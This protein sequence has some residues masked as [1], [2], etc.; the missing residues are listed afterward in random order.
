MAGPGVVWQSPGPERMLIF[1]ALL[2]VWSAAWIRFR[3]RWFVPATCAFVALYTVA[4]VGI[5]PLAATL[6][7]LLACFVLGRLL[8]G[9]ADLLALLTGMCAI[10]CLVSLLA[11]FPVNYPATYLAILG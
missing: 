10:M 8:T 3:P 7:F 9:V 6:F 5:L 4:A 1:L 2:S 11:H